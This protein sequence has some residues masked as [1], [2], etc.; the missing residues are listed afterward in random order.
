ME[1]SM[2]GNKGCWSEP[3]Y[4]ERFLQIICVSQTGRALLEDWPGIAPGQAALGTQGFLVIN[5]ASHLGD[6]N[7]LGV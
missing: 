4:T 2:S 5:L 6:P 7:V 1:F 3:H